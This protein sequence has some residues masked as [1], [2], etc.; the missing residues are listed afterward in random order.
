MM[1]NSTAPMATSHAPATA[2]VI[3]HHLGMRE[4]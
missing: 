3:N 4:A 1:P 2:I